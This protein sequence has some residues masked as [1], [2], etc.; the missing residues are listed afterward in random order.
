MGAA[1]N[2]RAIIRPGMVTAARFAALVLFVFLCAISSRLAAAPDAGRVQVLAGEGSWRLGPVMDV[3]PDPERAF[4]IDDVTAGKAGSFRPETRAIP[5]FP[6]TDAAYWVRMRVKNDGPARPFL[7]S[8][9]YPV[10]DK[11]EVWI[12]LPDG[13][14]QHLIAGDS[15]L[16]PPPVPHRFFLFPVTLEAGQEADIFARVTSSSAMTL[17]F[18]IKTQ[19]AFLIS[20]ESQNLLYGIVFGAIIAAAA[21]LL[22]VYVAVRDP[23]HLYYVAMVLAEGIYIAILAGYPQL[24]LWPQIGPATNLIHMASLAAIFMVGAKFAREFLE[25]AKNAPRADRFWQGLQWL[26]ALMFLG[27]LLP[28]PANLL[29][30]ALASVLVVA[31]GPVGI[32][33]VGIHLWRK[34]VPYAGLFA[35]GWVIVN[36]SS[37]TNFLRVSGLVPHEPFMDHLPAVG[38]GIEAVIFAGALMGR[39]IAQR[40][41]AEEHRRQATTDPLTGVANRRAFTDRAALAIARTAQD[42]GA[43]SLLAIDIDHF[44]RINDGYGHDVGDE[45]LKSVA[46]VIGERLRTDDLLAR[47][48]GEEF[49]VLMPGTD[50]AAAERQAERLREAVAAAV[51]SA[52]DV[53]L[54]ATISIGI[55]GFTTGGRLEDLMKAADQALYQAKESGRNRVAVAAG[56]GG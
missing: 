13:G 29:V 15:E 10:T 51:I 36:V 9:E 38:V 40:I 25:L 11:V 19:I 45:A 35:L 21:Y 22:A 53:R 24:Y 16:A 39:L 54:S 46:R 17:H 56:Q 30:T 49:A 20:D 52:Q 4:S 32:I 55:A 50:I 14:R 42:R 27:P 26:G 7:L 23:A 18:Q 48:G 37:L 34:G 31:V 5:S 12:P 44:K 47:L 8:Y 33:G 6:V 3:L 43:L 41:Q 2:A 28:A 1:M